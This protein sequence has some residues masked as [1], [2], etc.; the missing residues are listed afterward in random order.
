MEFARKAVRSR[1]GENR[2]TAK[3][4]VMGK[5]Q[6]T[7]V[8]CKHVYDNLWCNESCIIPCESMVL[9]Q[10]TKSIWWM[11]WQLAPT[12]DVVSCDKS[13]VGANNQ[14]TPN[15]RMRKLG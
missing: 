4:E 11:P 2:V 13:G 15:L 5:K 9:D 14:R 7:H 10:A 8:K 6:L 12:K 1:L 3:T